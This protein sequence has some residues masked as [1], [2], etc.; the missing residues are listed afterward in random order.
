M[1]KFTGPLALSAWWARA[2]PS[3]TPEQIRDQINGLKI[4]NVCDGTNNTI[5]FQCL[6]V[7]GTFEFKGNQIPP[8][9]DGKHFTIKHI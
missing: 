3:K 2:Y 9:L 4:R 6:A 7:R 8:V 5:V 1:N